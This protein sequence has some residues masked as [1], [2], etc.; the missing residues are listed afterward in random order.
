MNLSDTRSREIRSNLYLKF[1]RNEWAKRS[2][3]LNIK[4]SDDDIKGVLALNDKITPS[5]ISDFYFPITRLLQLS[6]NNN[7]KLYRDRNEFI[8]INPEKVPF[9][10]GV[11]GSVAVGKSTTSRLLKTLLDRINPDYNTYIVSTDNFL[12][13]NAR[14]EKENLLERKG[15]PES[16]DMQALINFLIDIK[17]GKGHIEIPV[18][19]HLK[20]DILPEKQ[21]I[22]NPDILILEGLNILQVNKLGKKDEIYVSD[23][24]DFSIFIDANVE[25]I[26]GWFIE[27]FFM[28]MDTAFRDK[29]SY[30]RKYSELSRKEAIELSSSIWDNINGKNYSENIIKTRYRAELIIEKGKNHDIKCILMK[31]L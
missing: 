24:L 15:F 25:D 2:G 27:R 26:K 11:T 17:S 16:F 5:E 30:F 9:I 3:N 1:D 8:G 4:M 10:I 13:S 20:Y 22:S 21:V 28:L 6:I 12:K 23:F 19:S 29:D 14:L 7:K 18:Y 31:K